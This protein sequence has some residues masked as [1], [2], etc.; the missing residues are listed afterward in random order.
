MKTT[1]M[2][3]RQSLSAFR[4]YMQMNIRAIVP[5]TGIFCFIAPGTFF[6]SGRTNSF[7]MLPPVVEYITEGGN[8]LKLKL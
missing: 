3:V 4:F 5:R 6:L 1:G 7:M 8:D 2:P